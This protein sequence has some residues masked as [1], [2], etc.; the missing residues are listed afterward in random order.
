G[1]SVY[2]ACQNLREQLAQAVGCAPEELVLKDG[3]AIW[4]NRSMPLASLIGSGLQAHG[5]IEPGSMQKETR[6]ATYGAHFCEAKVNA[7]TGEIR[8]T[9]WVSRF[10]SGCILKEKTTRSPFIGGILFRY[11]DHFKEEQ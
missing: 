11:G 3:A 4:Q 9:R 10:A 5:R 7:V 2:L 1:S 6:Q 8:V